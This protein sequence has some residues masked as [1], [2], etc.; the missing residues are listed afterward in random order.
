MIQVENLTK[1]YGNIPAIEDITFTAEKG[2]ILGFLGPNGAGK[3]TTMRILSCFMP[4]TKGTAKV[5]GYDVFKDSLEVRKRIGY[6]PENVPTYRDMSVSAYLNFVAQVRGI[7]RRERKTKIGKVM[8][9]CGITEVSGK[10]IGKLSKGYRQR[11]GIAQALVHDPEV[12]ILDEPTIGLDP[13]QIHGMRDLIKNLGG[14]RTIIL[15]THILPEVS[16]TCQRVVIINEGRLIAVDTPDNLMA[17]LQKGTK[18][19][20]E[21]EGPPDDI[22]KELKGVS[23]VTKIEKKD[24]KSENTFTYLID[25]TIDRDIRKELFAT[26]SKNGWSLTEIRQIDMSLEDIFLKLVTEEKD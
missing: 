26:I 7:D 10:L 9:E 17:R 16:M 12:L 18:I 1:Y 20:A 19:L 24:A 22:M 6:Q 21:I 25:S 3:T 2:E 15:S 23:G 14:K 4:A 13:R 5:A 11:V 8:D